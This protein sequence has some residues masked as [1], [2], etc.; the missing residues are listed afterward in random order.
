V[1]TTVKTRFNIYRKKQLLLALLFFVLLLLF[2][3]FVIYKLSISNNDVNVA[4][5]VT[6]DDSI[7]SLD[8]T[9][10]VASETGL[11][12]AINNTFPSSSTTTTIALNKDITLTE[13]LTISAN[14]NIILTSNKT[15]GF[16]KLFGAPDE[17]TITI[18]TDGKLRLDNI[19]VT[20]PKETTGRGIS[21]YNGGTLTLFNGE[22]VNNFIV[23]GGGGGVLV[24]SGGY[25][26]MMGGK[27]ANNRVTF[28]DSMDIFRPASINA[29]GGGI[30]NF[31]TISMSGG[32]ITNNTADSAGGGVYN[33]G[34]FTMTGGTITKNTGNTGGGVFV[35]QIGSFT[36]SNGEISSNNAISGG[37]VSVLGD[38][39]MSNGKI[40]D[41]S[42][43]HCG[44]GVFV[45]S[46]DYSS[47][48]MT[49]GT[50]SGNTA[51][52]TGGGVYNLKIFTN[53]G[54]KIFNNKANS[55]ND[56][57]NSK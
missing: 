30:Q 34:K 27:I 49:G 20:H 19:I 53:S 44:G 14:K 41:N 12:I 9:V 40:T 22:I 54:G 50:I 37:G 55:D 4:Y 38:F 13:T 42:V 23:G 1:T 16:Y 3:S 7:F 25:F 15:A 31:G 2:S 10:Y 43:S 39:T 5:D 8:G 45:S 11:K 26:K 48:T 52:E 32:T 21:I 18:E 51:T 33:S 57:F 29:S 56:V 6:V 17:N 46:G 47:F 36:L 24:Y 28:R 35:Y